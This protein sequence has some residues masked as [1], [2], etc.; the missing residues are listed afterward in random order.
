MATTTYTLTGA[1]AET[2]AIPVTAGNVMISS[3]LDSPFAKGSIQLMQE[4]QTGGQYMPIVEF[5]G[6][7][8][9]VFQLNTANYKL[10]LKGVPA[11]D[12]IVSVEINVV[13]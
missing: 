3:S 13:P 4:K 7:F 5:P 6:H 2:V 8:S 12:T 1:A 10:K 11:T 9:E